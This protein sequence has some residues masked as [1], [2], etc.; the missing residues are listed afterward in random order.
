MIRPAS[1]CDEEAVKELLALSGLPAAGLDETGLFVLEEG[2]NV[3]GCV[4][5]EACEPYALLRSLAVHPAHRG[6]GLGRKLMRFAVNE[7]RSR[8][9]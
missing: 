9:V 7:V 3:V 4:G 6:T 8:A 2:G 5:Y 1:A